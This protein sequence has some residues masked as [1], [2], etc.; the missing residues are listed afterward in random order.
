MPTALS[1]PSEGPRC[2]QTADSAVVL[3]C[4]RVTLPRSWAPVAKDSPFFTVQNYGD[5]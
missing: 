5:S 4:S 1:F 3:D 2:R